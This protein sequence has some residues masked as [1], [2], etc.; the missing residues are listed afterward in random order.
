M[1]P[2]GFRIQGRWSSIGKGQGLRPFLLWRTP[3][4]LR[5][6]KGLIVAILCA[7]VSHGKGAVILRPYVIDEDLVPVLTN[8]SNEPDWTPVVRKDLPPKH[9]TP[10]P[11]EA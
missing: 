10:P 4:N 6:K 3:T 2:G 9:K 1:D 5:D 8:F 7:A 11:G